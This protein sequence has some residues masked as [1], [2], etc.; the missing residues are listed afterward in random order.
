MNN[1]GLSSLNNT[2]CSNINQ[3][4]AVKFERQENT[5]TSQVKQGNKQIMLT[6]AGLS[7]IAIAGIAIFMNASKGKATKIS[8]D[9]QMEK[10]GEQAKTVS[11][12]VNTSLSSGEKI[13]PTAPTI[14]NSVQK[15]NNVGITEQTSVPAPIIE[16]K[17]KQQPSVQKSKS[18]SEGK[19]ALQ[20]KT[21]TA[22]S[23]PETEEVLI[24]KK[25]DI[26]QKKA[27]PICS[28]PEKDFE[29]ER[30]N[31]ILQDM[32]KLKKVFVDCDVIFE[33]DMMNGDYRVFDNNAF[34]ILYRVSEEF[35]FSNW[36]T[37]F[38]KMRESKIKNIIYIPDM[39]ATIDLAQQ[40]KRSHE[41]NIEKGIQDTFCGWIYS[42][43]MLEKMFSMGG[44][45]IIEKRM[46]GEL[47]LYLLGL[48]EK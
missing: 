40:M 44:Y 2:Y 46:A 20:E 26:V 5:H 6:L 8:L 47:V 43:D 31:N 34:F 38:Q 30:Y 9:G 33:F 42:E 24:S 35:C 28:Q 7:A 29:K 22:V 4:Q 27:A 10:L 17:I 45:Q 32:E 11:D 16:E 14:N 1:V 15:A 25:S 36:C 13:I 19:I 21:N 3:E 48:E 23:Q 12:K 18:N 39:I 37:V 41:R